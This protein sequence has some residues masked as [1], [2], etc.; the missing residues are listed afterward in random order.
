MLT[1]KPVL[2][3]KIVFA[4]ALI[5]LASGLTQAVQPAFILGIIGGETSPGALHSFAII[6]MFMAL[7]GGLAIHALSTETQEPVAILWCAL[8]KL[9]ASLAVALGVIKAVFSPIAL[10]VAGFDFVS[11]VLMALFWQQIRHNYR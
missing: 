10:L 6:G 7:F 8:Q 1:I 2:L 11:F 4:I 3:L 5:T 9:G